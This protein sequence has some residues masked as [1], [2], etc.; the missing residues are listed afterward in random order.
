M[1][2]RGGWGAPRA[3]EEE[4]AA[5]ADTLAGAGG[6]VKGGG[7]NCLCLKHYK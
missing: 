1:S 3:E 6:Q 7:M 4:V 2:G 5:A